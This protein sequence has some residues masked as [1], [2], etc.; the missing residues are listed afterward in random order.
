M[1][2]A[3]LYAL[4]ALDDEDRRAL[5]ARLSAADDTTRAE[6][7]TAV[8][9]ARETMAAASSLVAAAPPASLRRDLLRT[10]EA[11]TLAARRHGKRRWQVA[12][13]SVAAAAALLAG[14]VVIGREFTQPSPPP[15]VSA[16]I[17]AAP[18]LQSSSTQVPGGGTATAM[19][20][21]QTDAAM[22]V[23]NGVTPPKADT[24]YQ[25]WLIRGNEPVPAGTMGQD[26]VA[27]TTTAVL[28]DL[29]GA[30]LLGFTVEPPG[31]SP[32]PTGDMFASIPLT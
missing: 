31:G 13:A 15:S 24:V 21:K 6:F 3:H 27:A 30:T 1:E 8:R 4:H 28:P 29:D 12:V 16:Q 5:D 14:G 19:Y 18:D 32:S 9:S 7:E 20:S 23:M 2:W 11:D 17:L 25:M 22:L 10:V 26:Q